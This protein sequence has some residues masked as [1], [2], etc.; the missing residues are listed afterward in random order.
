MLPISV[1]IPVPVT[2]ISPRPTGDRRVHEREADPIAE[3]DVVARDRRDVLQHRRALAG[4]RG[5]L[6]LE[7]GGHQQPP[8][9]GHPVARFE[10]HDVARHQLGGVDLDGHPVAAHAGDVLQHLLE[11]GEARLRLG[12]LA[13]AQHGVEDRE[14]DQDDRGAR[15]SR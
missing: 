7:G 2:I 8:V 11:G 12:L 9:G 14:A 13:Q 5:L 15:L 10:E 4:E 6:D 1:S 3:A